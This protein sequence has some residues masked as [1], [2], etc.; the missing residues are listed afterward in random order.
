MCPNQWQVGKNFCKIGRV[1]NNCS[2]RIYVYERERKRKMGG[3]RGQK[4]RGQ[5]YLHI[6]TLSGELDAYFFPHEREERKI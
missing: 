6:S 2:V 3:G 1:K 5:R 4:L